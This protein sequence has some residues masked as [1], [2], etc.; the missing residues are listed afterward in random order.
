MTAKGS[1]EIVSALFERQASV[2]VIRRHFLES[3]PDHV[4]RF[5]KAVAEWVFQATRYR[6]IA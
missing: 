6:S 4:A 5:T 1:A 3:I 2:S